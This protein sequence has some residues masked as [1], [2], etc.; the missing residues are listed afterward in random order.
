[1][2]KKKKKKE[3]NSNLKMNIFKVL[4]TEVLVSKT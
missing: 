2:K 4:V 3:I 1:M